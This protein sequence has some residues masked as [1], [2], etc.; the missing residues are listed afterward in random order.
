VI[1]PIDEDRKYKLHSFYEMTSQETEENSAYQRILSF[2]F[3]L[4]IDS[5][6]LNTCSE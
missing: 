2:K 1:V 5:I 3:D 4:S 6:V